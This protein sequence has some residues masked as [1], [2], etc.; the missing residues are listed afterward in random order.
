VSKVV[1]SEFVTLDG[2]MEDPGGAEGFEHAGWAFRFNRG[3]EGDQFKFDEVM[4]A[5]A[6]LLGGVTYREF[7]QYWPSMTDAGGFGDK[8]NSMPKFVV[9]TTLEKAEWNNSTLIRDDVA[10]ELSKLKQRPGGD[11]LINGSARLVQSLMEHDLIDEYRLMVFPIVLG[12]GKRLFDGSKTTTTLRLVQA[13]PVGPD[14]VLVLTYEPARDDK[15]A[16]DPS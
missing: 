6:L 7:A 2:V 1:A 11:I 8:M 3:P 13:T 14:G 5:D 15:Q 10:E 16:S 4:N 12:S 9:S